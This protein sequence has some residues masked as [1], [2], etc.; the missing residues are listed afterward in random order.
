MLYTYIKLPEKDDITMKE[1][2]EIL[3]VEDDPETCAEFA[4]LIYDTDELILIG[5]TNNDSKAL[6]YI[7]DSQPDVVILDLE[8]HH[9]SGNGLNVLN[10]MRNIELKKRP[11]MLI[12]TN[13]SSTFTYESARTL[14]AD[15][16]MSKHQEN[17]S[18]SGVL[19]FLHIMMPMIKAT[20]ISNTVKDNTSET[21]EQHRRRIT[22]RIMNVGISP[23]AVGYSYLVDAILIMLKQP[24][25][26][27][28]TVIAQKYGKTDASVERAM[29]N[30]INR[31]WRTGNVEELL[32]YYT[33]RIN[34]SL[35]VPTITEF[36]SYYANKL[37]SEY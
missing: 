6:D 14:G 30:A 23:K 29:Q 16:I 35:G 27:I 18:V 34:P 19:D 7:R 4:E 20:N 37:K 2:L 24:T 31:A 9:G 36:I 32:F 3:L 17:Y 11:Y 22:T 8:L 1:K 10:N 13:N 26:N 28:N 15:F 21:P 5:V 25:Q 33:A 12:T